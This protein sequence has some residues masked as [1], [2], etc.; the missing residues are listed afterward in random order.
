MPGWYIGKG[1]REYERYISSG[2]WRRK[3]DK[4]LEMDNHTCCV[5]GCP[6]TEVHHLTYD[7]FRNEQMEDLVSLCHRC[8]MKAEELYD[9]SVIP[10]A[11]EEV[12]PEGNTFMA[13][14][15][16]DADRLV[17]VI[18]DYL[19]EVRG[20]GFDSLMGLRQPVD[21]EEKKYWS[22][23]KN[24][25]SALCRKRYSRNCAADRTDMMIEGIS[26][27]L[28]V[29]CL[30]QIEHDLRNA[31]QADLHEIAET[32]Y[33]VFGKWKDVAEY[34]GI[35]TGILTK[36]RKDDGSSFGPTLREAVLFYCSMDAAAGI[37]PPE[38]FTCLTAD[39]YEHL[40][41]QASYVRKVVKEMAS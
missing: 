18:F 26:N 23:L 41:S 12:L 31:I 34:L 16:M 28:T 27:H 10:W 6:A 14:L 22:T 2:S 24:A 30:A 4:R 13:A 40:N 9:P 36:L 3:A 5:C 17:P 33:L 32:E 35:S 15:R 7:N 8:H 19:K 11:M 29:V 39:D 20:M 37:S 25:V 1:N 21:A 38:G